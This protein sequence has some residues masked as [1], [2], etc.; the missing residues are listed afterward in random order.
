VHFFRLYLGV[1]TM[2]CKE[3]FNLLVRS[4]NG[5]KLAISATAL[6][7]A[8]LA[9]GSAALAEDVTMYH[10]PPSKDE[11]MNILFP[12]AK[13]QPSTKMKTRSIQWKTPTTA[14]DSG[15]PAPHAESAAPEPRAESSHAASHSQATSYHRARHEGKASSGSAT[16]PRAGIL[17]V[18]INFDRNST[19]IKPEYF[20]YLDSIGQALSSPEAGGHNIIVEGHTDAKGS[21]AYNQVLSEKRAEA[22]RE[23]LIEKHGVDPSHISA[24]GKGKSELLVTSSPYAAE[25]RRVQ[26]RRGD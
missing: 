26:F 18:Q 2:S 1:Q 8:L 11:V 23:Y 10:E 15:A 4:L 13:T 16:A 25:N 21:A 17:A 7:A 24:V 20:P 6:S 22:V 12:E 3:R 19:A 9:F 5:P 14:T